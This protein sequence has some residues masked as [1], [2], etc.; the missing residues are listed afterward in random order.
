MSIVN[1]KK[2][3]LKMLS[4][5]KE[6]VYSSSDI[7]EKSSHNIKHNIFNDY[8]MLIYSNDSFSFVFDL[9]IVFQVVPSGFPAGTSAPPRCCACPPWPPAFPAGRPPGPPASGCSCRRPERRTPP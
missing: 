1:I 6:Q 2:E 9:I 3:L 7:A 8:Y 5:E 4:Y